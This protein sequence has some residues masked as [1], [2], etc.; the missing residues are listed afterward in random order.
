N[1]YSSPT[2]TS[3]MSD[4]GL[5]ISEFS[6]FGSLSNVGAMIGAVVSGL[7]A[8][9]IRRKGALGIAS[10]PNILGWIAISFAKDSSLL[11]IGRS[12]T[13]LGVGIIHSL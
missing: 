13:G 5:T 1:G 3:I 4:L 9:Y 8:D 12:L 11:Y 2:Q 10:V 7:I 6:L